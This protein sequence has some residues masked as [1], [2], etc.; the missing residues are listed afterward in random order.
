MVALF[1]PHPAWKARPAAGALRLQ[2]RSSPVTVGR[3]SFCFLISAWRPATNF[4]RVEWTT[5]VSSRTLIGI[6]DGFGGAGRRFHVVGA[7][8]DQEILRRPSGLPVNPRRGR[9]RAAKA[10]RVVGGQGSPIGIAVTQVCHQHT[11]AIRGLPPEFGR[12]FI[13]AAPQAGSFDAKAAQDLRNLA[14]MA[15]RIRKIADLHFR[16]EFSGSLLALQEVAD[17][18]LESDQE[19]IR[20]D[21]PGTDEDPAFLDILAENGLLLRA[22]CQVIVQDDGL[23]VQHE[24]LELGV[25]FKQFQQS[26][27]QMDQ[28]QA[29][30]LKGPIPL[31]VP[32]GVGNNVKIA[33]S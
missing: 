16:T 23:A 31:A 1:D 20:Q 32:V 29:K 33:H 7:V 18:R 2:A 15:K 28:L 27:D 30:G 9:G 11:R 4:G 3:A 19:H 24:I 17:V 5:W 21:V 22:H 8:H 26:I 14:R 25:F 13:Q 12:L 6:G 10:G